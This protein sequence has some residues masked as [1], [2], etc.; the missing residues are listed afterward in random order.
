MGE[1]PNAVAFRQLIEAFNNG[2]MDAFATLIDA[3]I[4]WHSIGTTETMRA[5][6]GAGR[7]SVSG[8]PSPLRR[9]RP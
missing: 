9:A 2:E 1:H 8:C 7:S 6:T 4:V 3:D 5:C